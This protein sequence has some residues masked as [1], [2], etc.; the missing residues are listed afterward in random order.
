M[1]LWEVPKI[2]YRGWRHCTENYVDCTKS[3]R[4]A[5]SHIWCVSTHI[6]SFSSHKKSEIGKDHFKNMLHPLAW[7]PHYWVPLIISIPLGPLVWSLVLSRFLLI[8]RMAVC[9]QL[10]HFKYMLSLASNSFMTII[11]FISRDLSPQSLST[12]LCAHTLAHT[13]THTP[14]WKYLLF[15]S[16]IA[17]NPLP[18][19]QTHRNINA[20]IPTCATPFT[21]FHAIG[22]QGVTA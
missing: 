15:A 4:R 16:S 18:V 1:E 2:I 19:R 13:Y 7:I 11:N 8:P 21:V 6:S 20:T 14:Q 10:K 3:Q 5:V 12:L 22:A 9:P 17:E